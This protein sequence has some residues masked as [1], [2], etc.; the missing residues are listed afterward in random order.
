MSDSTP[1]N[2]NSTEKNHIGGVSQHYDFNPFDDQKMMEPLTPQWEAKRRVAS[3]IRRL[4][5]NLATSSSNAQTLNRVAET[6]AAAADKLGESPRLLGR[7][8]YVED[9]Q[10]RYGN[11][12]ILA[13][14]QGALCGQSNPVAPPLR[15]WIDQENKIA[16]G[17]VTMGWP[18]EGPPSSVHGG[19]VAAIFDDFLGMAQK[20][21]G[22]PGVTG[23]L[24]I[25]YRSPTPLNKKLRLVGKIQKVEG[26]KNYLEGEMWDGD[27]LTATAEGLFIYIDA[28][29]YRQI[30]EAQEANINQSNKDT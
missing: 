7:D 10:N 24:T 15:L 25:K 11:R 4:M 16:Y 13:Y 18:Y 2:S 21:T 6:I 5:D 1:N 22:Q 29:R 27:T 30:K 14:E 3:E 9:E 8:A 17:E 19:F 28:E 12:P 23:T 26:R 20:M